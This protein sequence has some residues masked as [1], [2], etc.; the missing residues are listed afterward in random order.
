MNRNFLKAAV[1]LIFLS[2]LAAGSSIVLKQSTP[3]F[4]FMRVVCCLRNNL[5]ALAQAI[6]ALIFV[7]GGARYA[8]SADD[9]EGR[10]QAKS[11]AVNALIGL[12]IVIVSQVMVQVAV[13]M[14]LSC[15]DV[16][17][18]ISMGGEPPM[19]TTSTLPTPPPPPPPTSGCQGGCL[20]LT[21]NQMGFQIFTRRYCCP[22]IF[23]T[24]KTWPDEYDSGGV[25]YYC[26]ENSGWS[27]Y[28]CY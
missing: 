9:P 24:C 8:Y 23:P 19:T 4:V 16:E 3:E 10:K 2:T 18:P 28:N 27:F 7:Y 17:C 15:K 21:K 22:G 26:C 14:T 13:G 20:T 6:A 5:I 25:H 11:L 1:I 12:I